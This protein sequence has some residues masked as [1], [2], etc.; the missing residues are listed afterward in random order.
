MRSK[1]NIAPIES[2]LNKILNING[3]LFNWKTEEYKDKGFPDGRHY[4][5]IAQEVEKV[6]PELVKEGPEGE[7][8]VAYTEVVPV[9]IEAMKEQQKEI[10]EL[11]AMIKQLRAG[12]YKDIAGLQP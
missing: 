11:R 3:V 7:K 4:G 10:E 1:E 12:I 9:L 8:A 5:V 6:L 2:P